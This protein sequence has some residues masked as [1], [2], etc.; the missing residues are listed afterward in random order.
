MR[1]GVFL[2]AARF[3]GQTD[4]EAL[5]RALE[6]VITADAVGFDTAWIAEHHFMPYGVCP[7]ALTF[8]AY[9]LG[10]THDISIGTAVS[11]LTTTH[12]VALGER[13]NLLATLTGRFQL[14]VGRGGPWVDLEVFGSTLDRYEHG[15]V[16]ALDLLLATTTNPTVAGDGRFPFRE[17]PVVPAP[18]NPSVHV[19]CTSRDTVEVAAA[20]GLPMLL[21]MHIGDDEKRELVDHYKESGGPEDADHISTVVAHIAESR[22]QAVDDVMSSAP[23]WLKEGLEAH[24]PVDDRPGPSRDPHAYARL[25]CDIHPVGNPVYCREIIAAGMARTGIRHVIAMVDPT[26]CPKHTMRTLRGLGAEVL[27]AL[28]TPPAFDLGKLA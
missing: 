5:D 8:A 19:A 6:A 3:P 9:A 27:P 16:D 26:G 12:P 10:R 7:D 4:K 13:A 2:L 25:L 18:A 22:E 28:R 14:G 15:F 11:V 23:G 20:R 17:V 21:G 24:V 1:F